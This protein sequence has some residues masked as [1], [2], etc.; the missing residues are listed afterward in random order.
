MV[1]SSSSGPSASPSVSI[2]S[3]PSPSSSASMARS[4]SSRQAPGAAAGFLLLLAGFLFTGG[5]FHAAKSA[6]V[7]SDVHVV[8]SAR[9]ATHI[10]FSPGAKSNSLSSPLSSVS[11]SFIRL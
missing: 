3:S 6:L 2:S 7:I 5:F 10:P 8:P 9:M 11:L 4:S 1:S